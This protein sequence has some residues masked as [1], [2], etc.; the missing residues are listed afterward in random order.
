MFPASIEYLDQRDYRTY[1]EVE[2][3]TYNLAVVTSGIPLETGFLVGES[4]LED[5]HVYTL[6]ATGLVFG[7]TPELGVVLVDDA[8]PSTE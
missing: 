7:G 8:G 5:G 6:F 1:A 4:D 3:K 2:A